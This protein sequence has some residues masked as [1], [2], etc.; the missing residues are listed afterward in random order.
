MN[1]K[2]HIEIEKAKEVVRGALNLY[3]SG[4][5]V[6]KAVSEAEAIADL[7][8]RKASDMASNTDK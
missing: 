4:S 6:Q 5:T 7:A 3:R 1:D 2:L 8:F